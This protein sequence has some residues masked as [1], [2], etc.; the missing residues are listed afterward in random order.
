EAR[1]I[2]GR[3]RR[4]EMVQRSKSLLER[5]GLDRHPTT[6]V[7]SLT[8]GQ[9]QMVEIARALALDARAVIMDEPTSSLTAGE[10]EHLFKIIR[11]LRDHGI[12]IIYISHRMEEVL[13]LADRITVLRDGRN[14]G[15]LTA[16]DAS[17]D[18]IVSLMVGRA[19]THRFPDRAP[20]PPDAP[21]VLVVENLLAPGATAGVSFISRR[22]EI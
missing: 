22:G 5:V 3:L 9:M 20:L 7:S 14:V 10:S 6:P 18:K 2:A 11:S 4:R 19:F 21:K 8:A 13:R 16:A 17:H 15:E 12:A 1:G